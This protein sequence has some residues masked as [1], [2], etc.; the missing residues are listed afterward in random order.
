MGKKG[1]YL[2]FLLFP[3]LE[4][5]KGLSVFYSYTHVKTDH[6]RLNPRPSSRAVWSHN[7]SSV[8]CNNV[9]F[10]GK[11]V[12]N[13]PPHKTLL[14]PVAPPTLLLH[15]WKI[16][17]NLVH[18]LFTDTS[19]EETN[20]WTFLYEERGINVN[21][22]CDMLTLST[23]AEY[24]GQPSQNSV[25]VHEKEC[26]WLQHDIKGWVHTWLEA[27]RSH[28]PVLWRAISGPAHHGEQQHRCL[29]VCLWLCT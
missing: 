25:T 9:C 29:W 1:R 8:Y 15:W 17:Y 16:D 7:S 12:A 6:P 26:K 11:T 18:F 22:Y 23:H 2:F 28:L 20:T 13:T 24:L 19:V 3:F 14:S 4:P 5:Q 10:K 21:T 27:P